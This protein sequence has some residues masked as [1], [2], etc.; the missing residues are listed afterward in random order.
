MEP[1][2]EPWE[3][4]RD[5]NDMIVYFNTETGEKTHQHPCD[6]EYKQLFKEERTRLM[7]EAGQEEDESAITG[8]EGGDQSMTNGG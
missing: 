6:E 7:K 5:I 8:N 1:V 2:P 3:A 4:Q